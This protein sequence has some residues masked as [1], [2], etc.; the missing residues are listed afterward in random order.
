M[1]VLGEKI[2][3]I[4]RITFRTN[5]FVEKIERAKGFNLREKLYGNYCL[6]YCKNESTIMREKGR[7]YFEKIMRNYY[8]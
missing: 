4:E 3:R 8:F 5:D 2:K 1:S 6:I 7:F